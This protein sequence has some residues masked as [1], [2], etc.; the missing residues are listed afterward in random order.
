[1]R[2][3]SYMRKDSFWRNERSGYHQSIA[4]KDG[5]YGYYNLEGDLIA[6]QREHINAYASKLG[7]VV[8]EE[9]IDLE[10]R[11]A[12]ERLK[13]D[14]FSRKFDCLITDSFYRAADSLGEAKMTLQQVFIPVGI[15]VAVAQD[16]FCSSLSTKGGIEYYFRSRHRMYI[17]EGMWENRQNAGQGESSDVQTESQAPSD[18]H[19]KPKGRREDPKEWTQVYRGGNPVLGAYIRDGETGEALRYVGR[20]G[21][22]A[23]YRSSDANL[24]KWDIACPMVPLDGVLEIVMEVLR[25][26]KSAAE[27]ATENICS[28]VAMKKKEEL[29]SPLLER[30]A[31]LVEETKVILA[32]RMERRKTSSVMEDTDTNPVRDDDCRDK[33][34]LDQIEEEFRRIIEDVKRIETAYTLSNPWIMRYRKM[35]IPTRIRNRHIRLYFSSINVYGMEKWEDYTVKV[36]VRNNEFRSLMPEEWLPDLTFDMWDASEKADPVKAQSPD[37]ANSGGGY[38]AREPQ[39]HRRKGEN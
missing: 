38:D 34:R 20:I 28:D 19:T 33:E 18:S 24:I 4:S 1:M 30:S 11:D 22:G 29:M 5:G 9:Y 35:E 26:E 16:E 8:E 31:Q 23:F 10:G 25:N 37:Q 15:Q 6:Q 21:K 13:R 2:C 32:G 39:P 3:V 36:S 14:C 17:R 27:W 7:W 12:F